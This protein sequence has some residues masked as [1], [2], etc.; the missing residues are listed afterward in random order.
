MLSEVLI[1][2]L[3]NVR[4][5]LVLLCYM[6]LRFVWLISH[7]FLCLLDQQWWWWK[8]DKNTTRKFYEPVDIAKIVELLVAVEWIFPDVNL[9]IARVNVLNIF[10]SR[11][12]WHRCYGDFWDFW[13]LILQLLHL[14]TPNNF[15]QLITCI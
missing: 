3:S 9:N 6:V 2:V 5:W 13:R 15:V 11:R 10:C 7:F 4:F 1:D 12:R 8:F 14:W